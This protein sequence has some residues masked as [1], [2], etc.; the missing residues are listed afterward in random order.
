MITLVL[1]SRHSIE[2]RSNLVIIRLFSLDFYEV[3]VDVAESHLELDIDEQ[4][5]NSETKI[6]TYNFTLQKPHWISTALKC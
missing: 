1:V 2:N 5:K 3:I 4:I 6:K